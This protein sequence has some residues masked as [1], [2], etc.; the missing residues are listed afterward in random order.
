MRLAWLSY[1]VSV[2]GCIRF[3][4]SIRILFRPFRPWQPLLARRDR[5]GGGIA[6][7]T[8]VWAPLFRG[9][10]CWPLPDV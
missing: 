1:F 10:R 4:P 7:P 5:G 6:R 8:S 2:G 3:T 9:A